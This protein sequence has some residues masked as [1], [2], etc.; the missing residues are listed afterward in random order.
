MKLK[1]FNYE[2][3]IEIDTTYTLESMDNKK[4]DYV[5]NPNNLTRKDYTKVL[6]I[7]IKNVY[8]NV[9]NIALIGYIYA[10]SDD[11]AVLEDSKLIILM[12][13]TIIVIELKKFTIKHKCIG[14]SGCYFSI[15]SFCD[16]YVIY[17]EQEII[18][19]NLNLEVEWTFSGA[20][21]FVL[22]YS[23]ESAFKINGEIIEL[24]DWNGASYKI[25][26][27]GKLIL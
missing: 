4:Y 17:G 8:G 2:I 19:I 10:S 7:E 15:H 25:D 11:Y 3:N 9:V 1:N 14:D 26:K 5:F 24:I 6:G 20:D 18:K 16:G 13:S 22:P 21:I 23:D 27:Y 12:D